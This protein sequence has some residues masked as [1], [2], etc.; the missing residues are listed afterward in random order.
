MVQHSKELLMQ[1][2]Q[3]PVTSQKLLELLRTLAVEVRPELE[4]EKISLESSFEKELGLDSLSRVELISRIE[5]A[6]GLSLPE[7]TF[8]EAEN[9]RDLLRVITT[10]RPAHRHRGSVAQ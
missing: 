4:R 5:R 1:Q 6:F 3:S 8:A 9:G 7:S 10:L 2:D